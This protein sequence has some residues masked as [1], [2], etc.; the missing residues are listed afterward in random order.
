MSFGLLLHVMTDSFTQ[1]KT[2]LSLEADA[3]CGNDRIDRFLLT[4]AMSKTI[5]AKPYQ[6]LILITSSARTGVPYLIHQRWS[7][8]V[9]LI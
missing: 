2:Q 8:L 4:L 5:V 3:D 7:N 9:R 6:S 1:K